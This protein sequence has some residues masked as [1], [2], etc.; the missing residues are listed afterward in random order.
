ME[1]LLQVVLLWWALARCVLRQN[2]QM[3]LIIITKQPEINWNFISTI[4]TEHVH[5]SWHCLDARDLGGSGGRAEIDTFIP[6]YKLKLS[7]YIK[8]P[9]V[10]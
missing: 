5:S 6:N 8:S 3:Y 2:T 4:A 9:F 1:S 10:W 7:I